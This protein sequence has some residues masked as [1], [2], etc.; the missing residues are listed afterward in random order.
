MIRVF[1]AQVAHK[2]LLIYL[3][4]YQKQVAQVH[5]VA[6]ATLALAAKHGPST[7]IVLGADLNSLPG[8]GVFCLLQQGTLP[9]AHGMLLKLLLIIILL[10]LLLIK[11]RRRTIRIIIIE[12]MLVLKWM[13]ILIPIP[14]IV[15]LFFV[16][17]FFV[18][19]YCNSAPGKSCK[20]LINKSTIINNSAH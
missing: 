1:C 8:S 15:C 18:Y 10:I 13:I 4:L 20:K 7:A 3:S 9:A 19:H 16:L 11:R 14:I 2:Y 12:S 5:V 6:A 17:F